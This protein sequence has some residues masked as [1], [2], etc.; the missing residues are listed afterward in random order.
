VGVAYSGRLERKVAINKETTFFPPFLL[1]Q[2]NRLQIA[3]LEETE[4]L[5]LTPEI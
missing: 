3:S 1:P 2:T 4:I 5:T